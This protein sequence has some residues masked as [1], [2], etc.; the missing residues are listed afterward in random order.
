MHPPVLHITND[1]LLNRPED[2]VLEIAPPGGSKV[3]A[4]RVVTRSRA[5][6]TGKYPSWKVGRMVQWESPNELNAFRLL[7]ANPHV[8]TFREQPMWITYRLGGELFLHVP[9]ALVE[10]DV[11]REVWEVKPTDKAVEPQCSERSRLLT[12]ALPA[13]GY[14][15]RVVL[16]ED[17][18]RQ[19]RLSNVLQFLKYGR[20]EM[21]LVE[22]E[23]LRRVIDSTSLIC[24]GAGTSAV[25]GTHGRALIARAF[26]EGALTTDIEQPLTKATSFKSVATTSIGGTNGHLII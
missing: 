15:Y 19:P 14:T 21:T 8:R 17:L 10:T 20:R 4:R 2:G 9:D 25:L 24:W 1:A 7:D 12:Q 3:R 6:A 11:G 5:R 16:A 22:R 18:R 26:L 13:L 23:C